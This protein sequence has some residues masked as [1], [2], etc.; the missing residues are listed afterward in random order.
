MHEDFIVAYTEND[1][2]I[3]KPPLFIRRIKEK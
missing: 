3:Y 1:R 2:I